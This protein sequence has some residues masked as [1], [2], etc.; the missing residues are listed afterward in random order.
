VDIFEEISEKVEVVHLE[1]T[2]EAKRQELCK[3]ELGVST[4]G[5]LEAGC[6]G[7]RKNFAAAGKR[8]LRRTAPSLQCERDLFLRGQ[9]RSM[10]LGEPLIQGRYMKCIA[11]HFGK[12]GPVQQ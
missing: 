10:L 3:K 4:I 2:P 9:A 8:K 12:I 7:S 11:V 1:A 5:S 6:V